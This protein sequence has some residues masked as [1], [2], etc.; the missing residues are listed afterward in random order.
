MPTGERYG[1]WHVV[2]ITSMSGVD[3]NDAAAVLTQE[4]AAGALRVR[5]DEGRPVRISVKIESCYPD[6]EDFYQYYSIPTALWHVLSPG[7]VA[8]RLEADF[9]TWLKQARLGCGETARLELFKMAG[10]RSAARDFASRLRYLSG[11]R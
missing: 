3:G 10:L 11:G 6:D 5:W 7:E 1:A 4:N 8:D 9:G 2:S